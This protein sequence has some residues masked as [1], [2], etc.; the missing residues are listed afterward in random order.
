MNYT[1]RIL[2]TLADGRFHSGDDLGRGL[3]ISRSSVWKYVRRIEALGLEVHAVRGRGYRLQAA[4]DLLDA[5]AVR[6]ALPHEV[7]PLLGGLVIHPELDSTNRYL[8]TAVEGDMACGFACLAERQTGGRGRRGRI[9]ISPFAANLYMSVYWRFS[10]GATGL[11]GLSLAIGVAVARVL[12]AL[13]I[14]DMGLKWPND[15]VWRQRKLGGILIELAGEAS[16]PCDVV[17]GV[18]INVDMP[19]A[20]GALVEQPWTDLREVLGPECPRR[21]QLAAMVLGSLLTGLAEYERCGLE[22]FIPEWRVRDVAAGCDVELHL[23][24]RRIAGT[25]LGIDETGALLV[26]SGDDTL[27]FASGEVSLRLST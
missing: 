19:A 23:P 22:A 15:L 2:Q 10:G 16:G 24:Q 7:R 17:V 18:G 1:Y 26:R 4:L 9:W 8:R 11:A 20:S 5:C 21:N 12:V 13:G 27:R 25:A 6:A 3:G 14:E